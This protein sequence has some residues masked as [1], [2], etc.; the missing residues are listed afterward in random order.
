MHVRKYENLHVFK[1]ECLHIRNVSSKKTMATIA[2][3]LAV[4]LEAVEI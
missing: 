4:S 1:Y 3:K 2:E